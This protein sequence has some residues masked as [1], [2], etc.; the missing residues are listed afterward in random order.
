[1]PKD[2]VTCTLK[3]QIYVYKVTKAGLKGKLEQS[4]VE[5]DYFEFLKQRG[6][7]LSHIPYCHGWIETNIGKGLVYDRVFSYKNRKES[8][9]LKRA[10]GEKMID[11]NLTHNMLDEL[12]RFISKERIIVSD[13]SMSNIIVTLDGKPKL[14]LVDGIGG[15]DFDYKYKIKKRM[16]FYTRYKLKQQHRKIIKWIEFELNQL[17]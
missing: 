1:M 6:V 4:L 2:A 9:T 7:L 10:F 11:I 12:C 13:L 3:I 17:K 15:R 8:L 5:Y 14:Y 16:P